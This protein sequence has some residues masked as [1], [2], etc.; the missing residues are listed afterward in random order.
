[1]ILLQTIAFIAGHVEERSASELSTVD[2]S[3]LFRFMI[4]VSQ[5][6][7][8]V[9][10]IPVL[11][12][13]AKI[14]KSQHTGNLEATWSV[15]GPLLDTA[16]QRIIRYE[17]MPEDSNEPSIVF[18]NED[19]DTIPERH[20]FLGNYRRFCYQIIEIVAQRKPKEAISHI[21]SQVDMSLDQIA[22][23]TPDFD[24]A[25]YTKSSA[26]LLRLDAHLTVVEA[27]LKGYSKWVSDH[28]KQPQKDEQER[29]Y[30]ESNIESWAGNL[31]TRR[32]YEDPLM[33]QRIIKL[34]VECSARAL[35]RNQAFALRVLEHILL[36]QTVEKPEY[37][38]YS[39]AARELQVYAT[40]ELRRLACR[41]ADYFATFYDQ[42][43]SKI[44]EVLSTSIFDEKAEAEMY[45]TLLIV[46]QRAT[47][48]D[49]A[50]RN[51][52]LQNLIGSMLQGWQSERLNRLL[53]GFEE[54]CELLG[55]DRVGAYLQSKQASSVLD[56][57]TIQL[58]A[59]GLSVQSD[60]NELVSEVPL[61]MTKTALGVMTDKLAEGSQPYHIAVNIWSPR[62]PMLLPKVLRLV[63]YTHRL[64]DVSSWPNLPPEMQPIISRVLQDRFW[65]AGISTGSRDD[66]YS[67]VTN[68]KTSLEGFAS[69]VRGKI[70][71]IREACYQ[72]FH[73]MSR[74]GDHFYSYSELPGPLAESLIGST[75]NLSSH[76]FSVL[77]QMIRSMVDDCPATHREHFLPPILS[78]LFGQIDHKITSEWEKID[79]RKADNTGGDNLT[80]EM[81]EESILRQLTYTAVNF[82]AVLLDP[83]REEPRQSSD[84]NR[85]QQHHPPPNP[86]GKPP[87][88][89]LRNFIL[90][91]ATILEPLL[92]FSTHA[93]TVHDS[94]STATI[95]KVLR[96]IV[97]VFAPVSSPNAP[98]TAAIRDYIASSV[99]KAAITA[100]NDGYFADQQKELASLIAT[101]WVVYGCITHFP[102]VTTQTADA[103]A[104]ADADADGAESVTVTPAYDR[105]R[106]S[107]I[108][109][110]IILSLPDM[111]PQRV[112][113]VAAALT[114]TGGW[115][116]NTRQ[117]RALVLDL[118]DGLRGVRM[119]ELGKISSDRA[120]EKSKLQERYMRVQGQG[121]GDGQG[122][123]GMEGVEGK[124]DVDV[125]DGPDLGGVGELLG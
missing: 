25:T 27:A 84:P 54:F 33:K 119:S 121:E 71:L 39:E 98:T 105:P 90:N 53:S 42:L 37:P 93:L 14:L 100:L 56:W 115:A 68:T 58:D 76:Q 24:P 103:E 11:H 80:L 28:G 79:R 86:N 17:L 87:R 109:R 97:P 3:H 26:P 78:T 32:N 10:S 66:F 70:R 94:R 51:N 75:T 82:V 112:D 13:W 7:S 9:V 34:A 110:D 57:S 35:E 12:A 83:F 85:Q 124:A 116:G 4:G 107:H 40:S 36:T 114:A 48:L 50:T 20:A 38:A 106:L 19:I 92:L 15:I 41:H 123:E 81:K 44:R 43:E 91:N 62:I 29:N 111:T 2:L 18:I 6:Q 59:S 60:M 96:T 49:L 89:T 88:S 16:S 1:M 125:A 61:R 73:S 95:T 108:P 45:G 118:L 21:L 113:A 5:H 102:A 30:L 67:R 23:D 101:I 52:H 74:L 22:A 47:N 104:E 117:Q 55:I 8:L 31:L 69:F 64:H 120:A 65:Q 99:L 72:I 63:Q 77:L 46:L 122:Q